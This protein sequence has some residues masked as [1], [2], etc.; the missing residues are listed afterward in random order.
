[1][2]ILHEAANAEKLDR[3]QTNTVD[4]TLEHKSDGNVLHKLAVVFVAQS[5]KAV[6]RD[7][8]SDQ[9]KFQLAV[10]HT[11]KDQKLWMV[12]TLRRMFV[13]CSFVI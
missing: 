10:I 6:S 8:K 9:L 2:K 12:I 13:S 7:K 11:N 3:I 4:L 5:N 1:M